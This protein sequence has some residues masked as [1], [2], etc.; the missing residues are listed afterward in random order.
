MKIIYN[1]LTIGLLAVTFTACKGKEAAFERPT[2]PYKVIQLQ[3]QE[4]E[5]YSEYPAIS[6]VELRTLKFDQ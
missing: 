3:Q 2:Q 1:I 5:L 6:S 4:V